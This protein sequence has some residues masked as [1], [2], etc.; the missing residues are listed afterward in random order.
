[1]I[2][3]EGSVAFFGGGRGGISPDCHDPVADE[4]LCVC[5]MLGF[6]MVFNST[7]KAKR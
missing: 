1:M 6:E 2:R 4:I 3:T 7:D 5:T